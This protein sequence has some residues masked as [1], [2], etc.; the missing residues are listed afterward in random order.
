VSPPGGLAR[1]ISCLPQKPPFLFIDELCELRSGEAAAG[2]VAFPAGHPVFE[3]HLPGN[4]IVPGVILIE[5]LAQLAGI[6][7]IPA[8]RPEPITGYL[9][10]VRRA[11]FRRKVRPG[12]RVDLRARLLQR[13]AGTARFEVE[14]RVG[15]EIA[16]EGELV[17]GGG[18]VEAPPPRP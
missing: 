13:F 9:G 8:E 2:A 3:N 18:A 1:Y 14:A 10:E 6:I 11:R 7:L 16:A 5:A 17:L 4:P 15:S 12:E